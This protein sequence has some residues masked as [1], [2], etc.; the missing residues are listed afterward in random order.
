[1]HGRGNGY[2]LCPAQFQHA[3]YIFSKKGRLNGEI[4]RPVGMNNL[5]NSKKD[6]FQPLVSVQLCWHMQ[7]VHLDELH[8]LLFYSNQ[9]IAHHQGARIN[10]QYDFGILLQEERYF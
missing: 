8:L 5:L 2:T 1:M 9:S 10:T 3:L 6:E 4:G 7:G